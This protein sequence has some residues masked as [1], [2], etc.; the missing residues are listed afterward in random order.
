MIAP[1]KTDPTG[2]WPEGE[3]A[4]ATNFVRHFGHYAASSLSKPVYIAQHGRVGWALLSAAEMTRLSGADVAPTSQD[5][6]FDMLLD[7]ISTIVLLVDTD[8]GIT[9][10]NAAARRHFQLPEVGAN[11][12]SLTALLHEYKR[13]FIAEACSRVL[14]SGDVET[15]DLESARYPGR[16]L[17]FRLTPFPGGLAM[18]ADVVTQATQ[19]RLVL[20]AAAASDAAIDAT[21]NLG[22]GRVDIRGT[23]IGVNANLI[24]L[25]QSTG[26]KITGLK[27]AALFNQRSR[28]LVR[29][30]IDDLLGHGN[31]FSIEAEMLNGVAGPTRV[32]VGAGAERDGGAITGAAFIV[33]P[34][35]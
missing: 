1:I 10:M 26:E 25:A 24:S 5:A 29:D 23:I 12:M 30:A 35:A 20:S 33:M 28:D 9:R 16:M 15:F 27:L 7:S 3:L 4:T 21:P 19:S 17:H 34:R 22:R 31:A 14:N 32:T 13:T 8:L 2:I 18:T 11:P 6:R